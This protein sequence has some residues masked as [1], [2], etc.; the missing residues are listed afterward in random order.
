[1]Q[2]SASR[3]RADLTF[4]HDSKLGRYG[5]LRLTPAYSLKLVDGIIDKYG[6]AISVL[7][8]FS[9]TSTTLLAVAYRGIQATGYELNPFL[10][11][12]GTTKCEIFDE[13]TIQNAQALAM[14]L[15]E[16]ACD[17][18]EALDP[19][20]IHNIER[21]WNTD[22]LLYLCKL[23]FQI[24]QVSQG[25]EKDLLLVAFCRLVIALSNA[26]FNH[27]SMSFK[28]ASHTDTLEFQPTF[29]PKETFSERFRREFTFVCEGAADNPRAGVQIFRGDSRNLK[30]LPNDSF[31]LLITSPPYPNRMSYIRELRPY[32][33]W[34]GYL[35]EAREAGEL[36][37]EAIGGTWG[38]ATSRLNEWKSDTDWKYPDYFQEFLQAVRKSHEK[39]GHLLANYVAKYFE[40]IWEH[41]R[42]VKRVMMQGGEVHYIVGNSVFY[43]NLLPVERIYGDMFR[44]LG[45]NN[46]KW[47]IIRKRNSKKELY[48]FDVHA[49]V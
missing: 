21:W 23:K 3:Q 13:A 9:G 8:P 5:W 39:N 20:R 40:D 31:D 11:W 45:F 35:R 4:R 10:F 49:T 27:Q 33:Y 22:E 12:F 26:A 46:V 47:C 17:S 15:S 14:R 32:M 19:P 16:E 24:D 37:W 34:L 2:T 48:E 36:D 30:K 1:M 44:A 43:T 41:I 42:N 28:D 18:D 6:E 25:H 7:D 29:F 38:I